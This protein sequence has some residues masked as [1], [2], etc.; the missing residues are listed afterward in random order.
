MQARLAFWREKPSSALSCPPLLSKIAKA[1][2]DRAWGEAVGAGEWI[3]KPGPEV[4][5][6]EE[7]EAEQRDQI[8][9]GPTPAG[10]KLEELQDQDRDQSR[11]ELDLERVGA[12]ADEGLNPEVLLDGLEKA[13]DLPTLLVER[14]DRRRSELEVVRQ[15]NKKSVV[16]PILDFNSSIEEGVRPLLVSGESNDLIANYI[17]IGRRVP[18][19]DN[20]ILNVSLQ[21]SHEERTAPGQFVEPV[22]VGVAAIKNH[23]GPRW[24]GHPSC[25]TDV[26]LLAIGDD[27]EF[28]EVSVMVEEKVELD[29]ALRSPEL[30]P[31]EDRDAEV[32]DGRIQR[33]QATLES[34]PMTW[35]VNAAS[36]AKENEQ[37][38]IEGPGAM[39]I[40][41]GEGR[42]TRGFDSEVIEFPFGGREAVANLAERLGSTEVTE[43]HRDELLPAGEAASVTL[44]IVVPGELLELHPRKQ[45]ENLAEDGR[46]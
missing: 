32:D 27:G 11:P 30:G 40:G 20:L 14:R 41:V 16:L 17:P 1:E 33:E 29:G 15:Q 23:D 43:K 12:G 25:N 46:K 5:M 28:R 24:D 35:R 42:T 36:I 21:T 31:V 38:P 2:L 18:I 10:L 8:R 7:V 34:K 19:F 26:V 3:V 6:T 9:K 44:G 39:L 4:A 22:E 37:I 45:F 13:L